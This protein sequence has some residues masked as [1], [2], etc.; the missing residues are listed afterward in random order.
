VRDVEGGSEPLAPR[1]MNRLQI[2]T[3]H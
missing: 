3:D 1:R 2:A